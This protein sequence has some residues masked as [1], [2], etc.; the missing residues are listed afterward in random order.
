VPLRLG[1]RRLV[2]VSHPSLVEEVL[3]AKHRSFIKTPLLRNGRRLLGH[4][5]LTSEGDLWR[6]QRRLIQPAFQRQRLLGYGSTMVSAADQ[7]LST[8]Q[9]GQRRDVHADMMALTLDIALRTLFGA[10]LGDEGARISVLVEA[11]L[12][13][14]SQRLE[15]LSSL[16][17]DTW[18]IPGNLRFLRSASEL[19]RVV[20][21]IIA[22]RQAEPP[23]DDLLQILLDARDERGAPMSRRQLKDEVMTLFLAG[24]ETTA[25]AL[26]W[27]WYLLGTH[28]EVEAELHASLDRTLGGRP[29]TVDDLPELCFVER[30]VTESMRLLPPV[31]AIG[32]QA[33]E[34]VQI[35]GYDL[36]KGTLVSMSQWVMHRDPRWFD[37][38]ERF[39]PDRWLDGHEGQ[40]RKPPRYAYLPFG[41]GPRQCIGNNF[42][43]L[44]ATLLLAALAQRF[45]FELIPDHPIGLWPS[46]TLRP[47]HG[48]AV[49][50]RQ[51]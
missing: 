28:P 37:D 11:A 3:V 24:H 51:R 22:R 12:R 49:T 13:R 9:D 41:G 31:W 26:S 20:L 46:A 23:R 27:T 32:R 44:E 42:A 47:R 1:L 10:E 34:P 14:F 39:W 8:W 21:T 18:P 38:P 29:P 48:I 17:P 2:L 15:S 45:R 35:G 25:S 36:P 5:L 30:V 19:D 4:G 43:L 7:L 6:R 50:L 33:I 40:A 16:V